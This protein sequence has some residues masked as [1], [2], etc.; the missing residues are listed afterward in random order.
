VRHKIRAARPGFLIDNY[1]GALGP[2]ERFRVT[3]WMDKPQVPGLFG[4]HAI[5]VDAQRHS[6]SVTF[7]EVPANTTPGPPKIPTPG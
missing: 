2:G 1:R 5:R 4:G 3:I 6:L 7:D